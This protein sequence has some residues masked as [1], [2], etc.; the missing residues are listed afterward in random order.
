MPAQEITEDTLAASLDSLLKAA[1]ATDKL[2]KGGIVNSGFEDEDG[3]QGGGQ[4]SKSDAGGIEELMI[5]KLVASGMDAAAAGEIVG[6]LNEEGLLGHKKEETEEEEEEGK[7]DED[8]EDEDMRGYARGYA[9]AMAKMGK[10]AD[11]KPAG[12]V[13]EKSIQK[14]FADDTDIAAGVNA[15]PFL[16]ALVARTT[17][18]FGSLAKSMA[19]QDKKQVEVNVA[20]ARAVH[21]LGSLVKSQSSVVGELGMRLGIVERQPAASPKGAR[22]LQG[23]Q[24]LKKSQED[25]GAEL[26]KSGDMAAVLSYM[27]FAKGMD[28]IEGEPIGHAVVMAEAGGIISPAVKEH[29]QK[30]LTANPGERNA[31]I[32]YR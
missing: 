5:G 19:A 18:S 6:L 22:T 15:T 31:A 27:R 7:H 28:A 10:S 4:G 20:L 14:S 17:E 25:G 21:Q 3:K 30:W 26:L 9:D 12:E 1:G 23:A 29:V 32:N 16:E 2:R 11:A 24:A 8:E 13:L